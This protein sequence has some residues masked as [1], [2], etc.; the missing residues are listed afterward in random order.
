MPGA[1]CDQVPQIRHRDL[2]PEFLNQR[3][4]PILPLAVAAVASQPHHRQ[5]PI[6]QRG[7]W[8]RAAHS[9]LSHSEPLAPLAVELERFRS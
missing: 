6:S 5:L 2:K 3:I 9:I 4:P 1:L 7:R 8:I